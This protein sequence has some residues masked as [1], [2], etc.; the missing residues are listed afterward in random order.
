LRHDVGEV[1]SNLAR[2]ASQ[3]SGGKEMQDD[4][5]GGTTR[6]EVLR[7]TKRLALV[8]PLAGLASS[9][10][11]SGCGSGDEPTSEP[12][13]DPVASKPAPPSTEPAPRLAPEPDPPVAGDAAGGGGLVTDLAASAPLVAAL[14][15]T[16][17]S[18]K[19]DQNCAGCQLF[20]AGGGG[21]GKCQ[22]FAQGA[23]TEA[24]WCASWAAKVS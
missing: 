24:G 13:V 12:Q 22:L 18:Q 10:W 2:D 11:L 17:V 16:N 23:V 4:D 9:A 3:R 8:L 19:A 1:T 5:R 21:L 20:T 7:G 14:Q 15:Y 6:R